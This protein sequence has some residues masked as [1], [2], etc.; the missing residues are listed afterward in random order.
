MDQWL[1]WQLDHEPELFY[2]VKKST[3]QVLGE[4]IGEVNRAVAYR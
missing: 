1:S 4:G 3:R 2:S